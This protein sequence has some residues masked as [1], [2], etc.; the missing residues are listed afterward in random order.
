MTEAGS[1]SER[2]KTLTKRLFD[3][4]INPKKLGLADRFLTEDRPDYMENP[5]PFEERKGYRGLQKVLGSF[6]SAFPDM[7][8]DI[9][10]MAAEGDI[11]FVYT[12]VSGTHD[13]VLF[14][15]P[16]TRKKFKANGV[17]IFRFNDQ[18]KMTAHWG[19]FDTSSMMAQLGIGQPPA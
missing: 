12:A 15:I 14:G 7:H 17:D 6:F 18:G 3:E 4:V 5:V 8:F 1:N 10:M 2:N 9:E 11:V 16:P 13:G 19:V